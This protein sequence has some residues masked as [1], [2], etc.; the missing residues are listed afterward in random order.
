VII[1]VEENMLYKFQK[2]LD[3]RYKYG[4]SVRT[5]MNYK[6]CKTRFTFERTQVYFHVLLQFMEMWYSG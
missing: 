5:A 2:Y 4:I 6:M 1:T 3:L